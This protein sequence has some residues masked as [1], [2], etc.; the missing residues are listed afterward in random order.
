MDSGLTQL[1]LGAFLLAGFLAHTLGARAHVPRV[2]L[3]L[4]I[5][6]LIGPVLG[7]VPPAVEAWFPLIAQI[8]LSIVGFMLGEQFYGK[9]L[10]RTGRVVL[11]VSIAETLSAALCVLLGLLM[12]GA[13]PALAILLAAVA[14]ATAPAATLDVVNEIKARGPLTDTVLGIVAIDDMLGVVLFSLLLVAA[15]GLSGAGPTWSLMLGGAWEVLGGVLTGFLFGFPMAV[16]T[17]RIRSGE[18]TLIETLGFVMLCGGFAEL[19]HA[20]Y[21]I[22]CI[23]MGAV[24]ANRA[25]HH[26]RPFH[27]IEGIS[28]PFLITFFLLAGFEFSVPA[29][30]SF[31]LV[32]VVYV[33]ARSAG[34]ILGGAL[35]AQLIGAPAT[36]RK[37]VGWCLLPQAGV[38]LGLGL[39]AAERFPEFGGGILSLLI[40]TTFLF[41]VLG[42]IAT[43]IALNRS[44][45]SRRAAEN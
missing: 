26:E 13:P 1:L 6:V 22:A 15:E 8:A 17:G 24:V 12:I 29:L 9:K 2:T 16:V 31:G 32:A 7:I 43:R 18:L 44:G 5:G 30:L 34:L 25:K 23:V 4:L 45:E 37:Y 38:A 35:G 11:A 27:E 42:P 14:P 21:L 10:K 33:L 40:G 20:S 28:H 36:V 39:I 19:I 3:L 41:E